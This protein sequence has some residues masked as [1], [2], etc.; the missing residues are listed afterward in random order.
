MEILDVYNEDG[1]PINKTVTRP[2]KDEDLNK[3]E[4]FAVS[5]IFIENSK[6]EFLIQRVPK[7][8]YSSTG[9]HVQAGETPLEAVIRETKEE[10][11]LDISKDN[12]IDL[13]FRLFDIPLRFLLYVKKDVE[14]KDLTIDNDEVV[15]VEWM[16]QDRINKLIENNEM[17]K[18]HAILYR[19]IIKYKTGASSLNDIFLKYKKY[20]IRFPNNNINYFEL[21]IKKYKLLISLDS[22]EVLKRKNFC[23]KKLW[24]L[25]SEIKNISNEEELCNNIDKLIEKYGRKKWICKKRKK[26]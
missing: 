21:F 3:G 11:G 24:I 2:C 1:K 8:D 9:G 17:K 19:E 6:G 4:H 15:G 7:G 20:D 23:N 26:K 5:I 13:G 16:S 10:I 14:L 18:G 25:V 12:I 22:I